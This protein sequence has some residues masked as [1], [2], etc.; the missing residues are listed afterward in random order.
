[1]KDSVAMLLV[2]IVLVAIVHYWPAQLGPEADPTSD[3]LARPPW[4][5]LPL[6][7]LLKY[8]PG[9][10]S[11]IPTVILPVLFFAVLFLL[12]FIDRR[13]IRHPFKRPVA[14]TMMIATMI[15]VAS[16]VALS[17][18]QDQRDPNASAKLK[19]QD[20]D[21]QAFLKTA[22]KVQEIGKAPDKSVSTGSSLAGIKGEPP[23]AYVSSCAVC[24]GDHG[25]GDVG[26]ALFDNPSKPSRS[27]DEMFKLLQDSRAYGLKDPMPA[28]FPDLTDKEKRDIAEWLESAGKK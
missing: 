8:F 11:L 10:L 26:P 14:I 12:P 27:K 15:V 28:S 1:F 2:F 25:E 9:K 4:Y 16:L 6:F 5:F 24:H 20:E 3:F 7:Q 17:K 21:A 13:E 23:V 22:F 18:Y 19:K